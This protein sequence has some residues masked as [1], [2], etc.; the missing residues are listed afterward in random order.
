MQV[1]MTPAGQ[2]ALL[3]GEPPWQVPEQAEVFSPVVEPYVF[4]GHTMGALLPAGQ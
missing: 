4:T 2:E 1:N 3:G